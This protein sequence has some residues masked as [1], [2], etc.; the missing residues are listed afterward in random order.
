[1]PDFFKNR[2]IN[3]L[4]HS[5]YTP[6]KTRQLAAALEV[7]KQNYSQFKTAVEQLQNSGRVVIASNNLVT[8]PYPS[9]RIIGKF[10]ANQKG[11]GF[12]APL[13]INSHG[14]LFIPPNNTADAMTG[15]IVA[16]EVVHASG[17]SRHGYREKEQKKYSGRIVEILERGRSKFVGTLIQK[18][19]GWAVQPDGSAFTE[20][21][22]VDD[23]NAKNAKQNDKVVVQIIS[24]PTKNY[25][26]RGVIVD[27]LGRAGKYQTEINS[28]IH[29]F[30]LPCEFDDTCLEQ[31]KKVASQFNPEK[32]DNREN[33]TEKVVITIDPEDAKDFDDAISLEKNDNRE[34]IT[35]K[36][37]I[38]IDP[39]DAKDFDDA[40]SLEKNEKGDWI[41]GVHIADVTNFVLP[42]TPLDNEAKLRG[43]SIY[44]PEKTIPMIPELLSN[45][46]CSLQPAQK[47][48]CKSIYLT[49]DRNANVLKRRLAN[50]LISST[51]RL[52]YRQADKALKGNAE[53]VKHEVVDLLKNMEA[54]S[55][56]IEKRREKNGMLHLDLPETEIKM[57][58]KGLVEDVS[59]ADDSYPHT[60]I[61]MFMVEANEAVASILDKRNVPFIRRIHPKPVSLSMQGLSKALRTLGVA[62]PNDPDRKAIQKVLQAAAGSDLSLAVNLL[63]LRSLEKAQYT[64][65]HIGHFALASSKYCHFTSP[66]RRYADLL[67]HRIV[68]AFL[69][70]DFNAIDPNQDLT[71]IGKHLSFMEQRAEDAENDLK[72]VLILQM[73]TKHLG[74]I[75]K[76]FVTGLTSFGAFV[77][78]PKFGIEGLIRF[79]DL[80]PGRWRFKQKT[81]CIYNKKSRRKIQ[82]GSAMTVQIASV[83]VPARHL[84]LIPAKPHRKKKTK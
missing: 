50:S 8:L 74:E 12:V 3:L 53:N 34:N 14:D 49:Y 77:N 63:V 23:V 30:H 69:K 44:L 19:D 66:I 42:Q 51:Q 32:N 17:K 16:A 41:L 26:P 29:Q 35:E 11:F 40:I 55:R 47:R 81:Q 27:V 18:S 5:D 71:E 38:T 20:S 70:N 45:G 72:T 68:D 36:V 54:L 59:P 4:K 75:H 67:V 46:I 28:V 25:P 78:I 79:E 82:F 43:N 60:I 58:Q 21:I 2:I 15:D 33:I 24:W 1:M 7:S 84:N 6:L 13:E 65:L 52:T 37:V 39:E 80:G 76:G 9:G 48:F 62:L 57:N 64:P 22:R 31:A 56:D 83:N 61:E 73:L 10:R